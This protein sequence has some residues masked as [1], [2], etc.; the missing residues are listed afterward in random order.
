[1]NPLA[2]LMLP[3]LSYKISKDESLGSISKR[4][5]ISIGTLARNS[6]NLN[7][8]GIFSPGAEINLP[9]LNQLKVKEILSHIQREGSIDHL[10]G[11]AS[12]YMLHG[13]CSAL[14][15]VKL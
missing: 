7:I 1:M 10:A 11:M 13:I 15:E 2:P 9:H 3:R 12:R 14:P 5:G 6:D 8:K 4:L